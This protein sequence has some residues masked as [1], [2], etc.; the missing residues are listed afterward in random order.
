VRAR[1]PRWLLDPGD[2]SPDGEWAA[3]IW[4]SWYPGLGDRHESFAALV[5]NERTSFEKLRGRDGRPV[6]PTGADALLAEG[7]GSEG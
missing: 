7:R 6:D 2:V 1:S 4:A 5:D 3:Y